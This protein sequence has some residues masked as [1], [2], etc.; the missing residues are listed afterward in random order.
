MPAAEV[1][2]RGESNGRAQ[3][4]RALQDIKRRRRKAGELTQA[5]VP[6]GRNRSVG[7]GAQG[8]ATPEGARETGPRRRAQ[9]DVTGDPAAAENEEAAG[10]QGEQQQAGGDGEDRGRPRG[11]QVTADGRG[12]QR[13]RA[14][15][16]LTASAPALSAARLG[17]SFPLQC[18]LLRTER[19]NDDHY[20][21]RHAIAAR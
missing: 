20:R 12:D 3:L 16:A 17:S 5:G 18:C 2:G 19:R 11:A 13:G 4:G 15:S 7:A 1:A 14:R 10:Q 9:H 6:V 21:P 8:G